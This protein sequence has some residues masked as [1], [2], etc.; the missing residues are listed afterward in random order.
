MDV[1]KWANLLC[2]QGSLHCA[3]LH[4]TLICFNINVLQSS[5][6]RLIETTLRTTM[7]FIRTGRPEVHDN[8]RPIFAFFH[9]ICLSYLG[10]VQRK[11]NTLI[12]IK[13]TISMMDSKKRWP[14]H[15]PGKWSPELWTSVAPSR[16]C[17]HQEASHSP[18]ERERVISLL[19]LSF[20][21]LKCRVGQT[22]CEVRG[23]VT[24]LLL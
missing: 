3:A 13:D 8:L 24:V 7:H 12:H 21:H 18:P 16:S 4:A 11:D 22:G 2:V 19:G 14:S 5:I 20:L 17:C 1:E 15:L 10:L 9:E 6:L 23:N